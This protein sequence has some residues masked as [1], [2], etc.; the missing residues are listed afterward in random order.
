MLV[1]NKSRTTCKLLFLLHCNV[2]CCCCYCYLTK[3]ILSHL[4]V[5][6]RKSVFCYGFYTFASSCMINTTANFSTWYFFY[7]LHFVFL[8]C[9]VLVKIEF[10][11][12]I[13]AASPLHGLTEIHK[14]RITPC[15][16]VIFRFTSFNLI[17][18]FSVMSWIQQFE[19]RKIIYT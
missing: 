16:I 18:W 4:K 8:F 10:S 9:L 3:I 7:E 13:A 15:I 1:A 19:L 6:V 5:A 14:T 17:P 2:F 12:R 11:W